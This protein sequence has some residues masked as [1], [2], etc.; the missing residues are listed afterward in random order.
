MMR[1]ITVLT[2]LGPGVPMLFQGQEFASAAPFQFFADIPE[3]LMPHVREGR[4]EF[5]CQWRSIRTSSMIDV[6]PDPCS[7]ETF[8]RCKLDHAQRKKNGAAYRLHS[9]LIRLKRTDPVLSAI[10]AVPID[11]AVLSPQAFLVRYFSPSGEDRLLIVNLGVD[12]RLDPAPEPL[13]APPRDRSWRTLLATE[14]PAY[15]G[16]GAPEPDCEELNWIIQGQSAILLAPG[17]R[18]QPN[19]DTKEKDSR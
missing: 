3:S 12:L 13:L 9:D 19:V 17:P 11:G 4:K 10:P 18:R 2:I 1:A 8:E 5:L 6:L 14:A 7:L 15:G 16:S